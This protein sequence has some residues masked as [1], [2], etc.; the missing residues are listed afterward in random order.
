MLREHVSESPSFSAVFPYFLK[1]FLP[2]AGLFI[3]GIIIYYF[4]D[5]WYEERLI[6]TEQAQQVALSKES[7]VR[8]VQGV[9]HELRY[10]ADTAALRQYLDHSDEIH[11]VRVEKLFATFAR[12]ITR[13]DQIRWLDNEGVERIRIDHRD[14]NTRIVPKDKMQDKSSR[15]YFSRTFA[16]HPGEIYIS[17]LDLNVEQG[18]VEEPYRP[19]LRIAVPLADSIGKKK[20]VLI[21]N[22]QASRMLDNFSRS[23]YFRTGELYLLNNEGYWLYVSDNRSPWGFMFG[24]DDKFQNDYPDVWQAITQ[25]RYGLVRNSKGIFSFTSVREAVIGSDDEETLQYEDA[26]ILLQQ[27]TKWIV[28]AFYPV[29][30]TQAI[31]INHL[32]FYVSSIL[33][34]LLVISVI[35]WLLGKNK[36]ERERLN[37]RLALHAR[38]MESATNGILITDTTPTVLSLNSAFTKLTGYTEKDIVGK[39]PSILGSGRHDPAFYSRMWDSLRK[40]GFWEGEIWNRHKNGELYPEW[41]SISAIKNH[42]GELSHYIGIFSVLAEQQGTEERLR[43]LANSDMLTGLI[44][45]NLFHDRLSQAI[46]HCRRTHTRAAVLFVDLDGFKQVNDA[47]GHAAGDRVLKVVANRLTG[48]VRDTDTV[49][50]FGGDEFVVLLTGIDNRDNVKEVGEKIIECVSQPIDVGDDSCLVGASVGACI[51]PDDSESVDA[52][53][54]CSDEAMYQAKAHGKGRLEFNY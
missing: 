41:M 33:L 52:L 37:D 53:L 13:Y 14:G 46:A 35:S 43:T 8:D 18:K 21:F 42:K 22:Y 36:W 6:E 24:S 27:E 9:V 50:R 28:V 29:A 5:A 34:V 40:H 44:N 12:N 49:A 2:L 39:N 45:R 54:N 25:Q 11:R 10:L 31:Y 47:M 51:Y 15:Y 4:V 3:L 26:S 1:N 17:P 38:V 32:K 48:C 30:V 7:L 19:M 23:R 16:L 20:G